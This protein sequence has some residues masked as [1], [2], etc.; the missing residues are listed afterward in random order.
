MTVDLYQ[1]VV[2]SLE[3]ETEILRDLRYALDRHGPDSEGWQA[4]V[5]ELGAQETRTQELGRQF[6][7]LR[8]RGR[9]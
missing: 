5:N 6:A 9:A 2:A 7:V 8:R 1:E 3:R 4:L